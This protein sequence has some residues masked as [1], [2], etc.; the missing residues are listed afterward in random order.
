MKSAWFAEHGL[1]SWLLVRRGTSTTQTQL[2]LVYDR[3]TIDASSTEP[4]HLEQRYAKIFFHELA[5]ARL[6]TDF[7]NDQLDGAADERIHVLPRHEVEAT[8]YA[9]TLRGLVL[10]MCSRLTRLLALPDESWK[11]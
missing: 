5:H 3:Q 6:H 9:A 1:V 11:G 4:L 2:H 8:H 10:G 7:L